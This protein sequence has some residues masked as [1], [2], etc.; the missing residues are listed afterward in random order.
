MLGYVFPLPRA[1]IYATVAAAGMRLRTF[2]I[3]DTASAAVTRAIYIYLGYQ[4]G[5]PAVRIVQVIAK[6]SWWLSIA[7][8]IGIFANMGLQAHRRR[9][10]AVASAA[11]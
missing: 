8:L 1:V 7:L 3:V 6:Y 11:D 5:E 10:S 4:I 9:R 2:L